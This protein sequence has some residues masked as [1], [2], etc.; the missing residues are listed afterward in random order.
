MMCIAFFVLGFVAG[1]IA[2]ALVS[3]GA[4]GPIE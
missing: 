4:D 2:L 1:I 3:V